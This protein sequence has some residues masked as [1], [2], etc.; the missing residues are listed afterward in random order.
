MK[1]E[2]A[3]AFL[4]GQVQNPSK[5]L[6]DE[7]FYYISRTTPLVNVDLLIQDNRKR[8]LLAWRDDEYTGK[9]WHF[10]GGIVRFKETLEDRINKVAEKEVGTEITFNPIPL[11]INQCI[12]PERKNRSHF[13]SLLY[14]CSIPNTFVPE[15]KGLCEA[16][17][18]YLKWHEKCP[19]VLLESHEMYKKY[20]N[21]VKE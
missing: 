5:G 14:R 16:S 20:I 19:N 13:I 12:V 4:D 18:G 1:I 15:N 8:T 6:P 3:I 17:A 2:K 9:G 10:P 21:Y 7:I 11:E